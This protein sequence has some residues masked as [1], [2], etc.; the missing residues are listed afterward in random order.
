MRF[1]FR[2]EIEHLVA[3]SSLALESVFG[4]FAG[5]PVTADSRD[6]LVVCRRPSHLTRA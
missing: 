2:F 4:D 1:F 6:Y 3:R 5:G